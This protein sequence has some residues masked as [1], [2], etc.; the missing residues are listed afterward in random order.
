[1]SR[2]LFRIH[3]KIRTARRFGC[4]AL[5]LALLACMA[6]T[7]PA[8]HDDVSARTLVIVHAS[9]LK[10]QAQQWAE[11]RQSP[12][13]G[14]WRIVLHES[15]PADDLDVQRHE[16]QTAIRKAFQ[17]AAPK[18]DDQFAVLLLGD[19][20][21]NGVPAWKFPQPDP[22]LQGGRDFEFITDHPYQ[23]ISGEGPKPN[24]ALGRI[25]A[26]TAEEA[27]AALNKIKSYEQTPAFDANGQPL[28]GRNR[29]TYAAGEGRFGVMDNI[30]ESLFKQMVD[31]LVPDAFDLSMTY[32]KASSIY[33]PP[34]S[35]LTETVLARMTEGALLFNYVGHG[36]ARG[37]DS[38]HWQRQR[39]AILKTSD[40][41]RLPDQISGQRPIAFF[42][43][44]ST[45]HYD[46]PNGEPS[47]AEAMLFHPAGPVGIVAGS[48]ITHPYANTILQMDITRALLVDREPTLGLLDLHAMQSMLK[49]DDVDRELDTIAAPI[50]FAGKW[51]TGLMGLRQMHVKL[52]NLLGDPAMRL[53]LPASSIN[54]FQLSNGQLSGQIEGMKSGKI[55]IS[56]Q[57]PRTDFVSPEKVLALVGDDDPDLE[58]K[59]AIN[60][61]LVNDR[62]V[63]RLD[64]EVVDGKFSIQLK[65]PLKGNVSII[66]AT[67]LGM[68]ADGKAIDAIGAIR[69]PQAQTQPVRTTDRGPSA[70]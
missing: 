18:A 3:A 53:A 34:P 69:L 47:L 49:V 16:I 38:L 15:K 12:A 40:L 59:A 5:C 27:I 26:R 56:A 65:E 28:A 51:K 11:Y 66:R 13:G 70:K 67:A 41:A 10:P 2:Y 62:E 31:R 39:L 20:E 14:S 44:C 58:A 32:A 17:N 60:Y 55:F 7:R 21:P 46:L 54:S 19:A 25:P 35:K 50:A 6:F 42:S 64:A 23:L 48:R 1:M 29:I 52:Y 61:P 68:D 45:G 24:F 8:P 33:C 63:T 37:F 36:Y 9:S 57:T 4:V 30:L 43:A 22:M